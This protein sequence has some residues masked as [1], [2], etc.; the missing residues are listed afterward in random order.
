MVTDYQLYFNLCR[1]IVFLHCDQRKLRFLYP[2]ISPFLQN[3]E[4]SI[5][6]LTTSQLSNFFKKFDLL[7]R[8]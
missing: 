6:N 1:M 4:K 3:F 8:K 7:S 2:A 5:I